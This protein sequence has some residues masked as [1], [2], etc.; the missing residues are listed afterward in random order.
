M[1]QWNTGFTPVTSEE[2]ARFFPD[3]RN[4]MPAAA[5][6]VVQD[7]SKKLA[8]MRPYLADMFTLSIREDSL[9]I[10]TL[11]EP[12][13]PV[14][15]PLTLFEVDENPFYSVYGPLFAIANNPT[16]SDSVFEATSI[17]CDIIKEILHNQFDIPVM[18]SFL[19]HK[20]RLNPGGFVF[21]FQIILV[22]PKISGDFH[23]L[24]SRNRIPH[25]LPQ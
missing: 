1:S 19:I 18:W 20:S 22:L 8:S 6:E 24:Q 14:P 16:T 3:V 4:A 21:W 5:V 2:I 12:R 7:L 13:T 15:L 10:S 9:V 25:F 23:L 11:A 17:A